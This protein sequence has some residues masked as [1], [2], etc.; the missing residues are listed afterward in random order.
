MFANSF[1]P[2]QREFIVAYFV[3]FIICTSYQA[4]AIL[5]SDA[6]NS[7]CIRNIVNEFADC[8]A[9]SSLCVVGVVYIVGSKC[10]PELRSVIQPSGTAFAS[11]LCIIVSVLVQPYI[12]TS[13]QESLCSIAFQ[14]NVCRVDARVAINLRSNSRSGLL[15]SLYKGSRFIRTI[16]LI[17]TKYP[18]EG[19]TIVSNSGGSSCSSGCSCSSCCSSGCTVISYLN[20][21]A[22]IYKFCIFDS[23]VVGTSPSQQLAILVVH[24]FS[25]ERNWEFIVSTVFIAVLQFHVVCSCNALNSCFIRN[26][27][28]QCQ[29]CFTIFHIRRRYLLTAGTRNAPA[30]CLRAFAPLTKVYERSCCIIAL[31]SIAVC[32]QQ[33]LCR[34]TDSIGLE[35][36]GDTFSIRCI[37]HIQRNFY[38]LVTRIY[39]NLMISFIAFC[40]LTIYFDSRCSRINNTICCGSCSSGCISCSRC[41][42]SSCTVIGYLNNQVCIFVFCI[43]DSGVVDTSPSQQLAILVVHL[44]SFERNWEF[45]VSTVFIAVLQFHVVCS[46]NALN[47][48]F[49][50]NV[51]VQ[52]QECFTI[53]HIR[54]RYLLTAGTRNAPAQC[55]RAF[56]PLTKVYE[57]SCCII[58]LISIAVCIQQCLCRCTDSIGLECDGDT[59]SIR[60]IVH[61]QRNFYILIARCYNDIMCIVYSDSRAIKQRL[62]VA[63]SCCNS[64]GRS[65]S[66]CSS[67]CCGCSCLCCGCSCLCGCSCNSCSSGR[68]RGSLVGVNTNCINGKFVAVDPPEANLYLTAVLGL[69]DVR[70][71]TVNIPYQCTGIAVDNLL[72][73]IGLCPVIRINGCRRTKCTL[74]LANLVSGSRDVDFNLLNLF[75]SLYAQFFISPAQHSISCREILIDNILTWLDLIR[76]IACALRSSRGRILLGCGNCCGSSRIRRRLVGVNTNFI[77]GKF[78]AVN[79]PEA[80]LYL[81]AVLRLNDVRGCTVNVPYQCTGIAI[82]YLL[83]I[84]GLCPV[85][86][87]NSGRRTECTLPLADL[88]SSCRDVDFNLLN[89]FA[90]LYAQFFI[91]PAQHLVSCRQILINNVLIYLLCIAAIALCYCCRSLGGFCCLCCGNSCSGCGLASCCSGCSSGCR[92]C[93]NARNA[94]FQRACLVFV[95]Q[96]SCCTN[97]TCIVV[98]CNFICFIIANIIN[99]RR[100]IRRSWAT[101]QCTN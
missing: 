65:C 67:L 80:N 35:C 13:C 17:L 91:S 85:T 34:C 100:E 66:G 26:V 71:C 86:R 76:A 84:F 19:V 53:F 27:V 37:V 97:Q 12:V 89:L 4:N 2:S 3:A 70:C 96:A 21:N 75:A 44:F 1:A 50:R 78:V 73:I 72:H 59:F 22:T 45:I 33:C 14:T 83:H 41:C 24:L 60:C 56:A 99:I 98:Q 64:C 101:N 10:K 15:T 6:L 49:I 29:E 43:F 61:I 30:Q 79:P 62:V 7:C 77:N 23:G 94:G 32:I 92:C 11:Q 47:S 55:L 68:I 57:R 18:F 81:T 36:D 39:N 90:S 87:I 40:I 51:V 48:C 20:D 38:I 16:C 28:V 58:A 42:G 54:R 8:R 46:C 93:T 88:I 25:F 82:N 74:P 69:D 52:C 31:I 63:T 9:I 95:V 5:I